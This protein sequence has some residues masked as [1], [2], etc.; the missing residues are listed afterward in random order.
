MSNNPYNMKQIDEFLFECDVSNLDYDLAK[1]FFENL[2]IEKLMGCTSF[3]KNGLY[4]RSYDV[5]YDNSSTL[6]AHVDDSKYRNIAVT[7][8]L[9]NQDNCLDIVNGVDNHENIMKLAPFF[10]LDG[11]NEAGVTCNINILP[12]G[13][14]DAYSVADVE[15]KDKICAFML[16]R[17]ILDNFGSAKEAVEYIRDYCDIYLPNGPEGVS[18]HFMVS[19]SEGKTYI[20]EFVEGK[21]VVTENNIMTN[22]YMTSAK[23]N[24]DGTIAVPST[25]EGEV[26]KIANVTPHGQGLE[27]Y[28][29]VVEDYDK[30]E[31]VEDFFNTLHKLRFT[32]LYREETNP[33]WY[34]D[35]SDYADI[36]VD[37]PLASF[38]E[39][40]EVVD[41]FFSNP[42]REP[43]YDENG[44]VLSSEQ[45]AHQSVWDIENRVLYIETQEKDGS[46]KFSL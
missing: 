28:N 4:G 15:S 17:F 46:Y 34:T 23:F 9:L 26:S 20:L 25:S 5:V 14:L 12:V 43:A 1:S 10:A 32:N 36:T 30:L 29:I 38:A 31:T 19:D 21:T 18:F 2:T 35:L 3:T 7:G 33:P 24:E 39:L 11:I 27:R 40:K 22:F 44:K 6:I 37:E 42:V 8:V 16:G 13:D 45:S 41:G